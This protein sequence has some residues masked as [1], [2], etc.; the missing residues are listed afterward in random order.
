MTTLL[1]AFSFWSHKNC[2]NC[3][4]IIIFSL[5]FSLCVNFFHLSFDVSIIFLKITYV[6]S[7]L[8]KIFQLIFI[9]LIWVYCTFLFISTFSPMD[10]SPYHLPFFKEMFK[11]HIL[12]YKYH[13]FPYL[14]ALT[15][16][17]SSV[18]SFL[19]FYASKFILFL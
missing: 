13:T 5:L 16:T 1:P 12:D 19:Y 17:V 9:L 7:P 10:A 15:H 3:W 8:P 4:T 2:L 6:M 11:Q 14:F 18:C